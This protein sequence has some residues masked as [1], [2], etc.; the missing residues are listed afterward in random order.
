MMSTRMIG[1][2]AALMAVV[3]ASLSV[4]LSAVAGK[5]MD[6]IGLPKIGGQELKFDVESLATAV[7]RPADGAGQSTVLSAI[8]AVFAL[9]F[10][11]AIIYFV[12]GLIQG[13]RGARGG[14]ETAFSVVAALVI[15]IVGFQVLA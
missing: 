1:R 5:V 10:L 13:L 12:F 3:S 9:L 2:M 14:V 8:V 11:A 4:G 6:Q 7:L 15:A